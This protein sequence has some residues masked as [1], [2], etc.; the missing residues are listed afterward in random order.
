MQIIPSAGIHEGTNKW[1]SNQVANSLLAWEVSSTNLGTVCA[2]GMQPA[3]AALMMLILL[4]A[5]SQFLHLPKICSSGYE[6]WCVL[7]AASHMSGKRIKA[8]Q[9]TLFP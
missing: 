6:A 7:N 1:V 5:A 3:P 8:S 2:R 9:L 4:S